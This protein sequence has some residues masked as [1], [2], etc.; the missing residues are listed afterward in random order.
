MPRPPPHSLGPLS[1]FRWYSFLVEWSQRQSAPPH[2]HWKSCL[3]AWSPCSVLG[4]GDPD[5]KMSLPLPE[6]PAIVQIKWHSLPF[7]ESKRLVLDLLL[8]FRIKIRLH[9]NFFQPAECKLFS[10]KD[11]CKKALIIKCETL[12]LYCRLSAAALLCLGLLTEVG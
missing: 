9:F 6:V 11:H 4:S 8:L 12:K 1:D 3:Q 5:G 7:K 2:P 10:P